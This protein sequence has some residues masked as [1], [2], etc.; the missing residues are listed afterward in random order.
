M[1]GFHDHFSGLNFVVLLKAEDTVNLVQAVRAFWAYCLSKGVTIKRIHTDNAKPHVSKEMVALM[2][3]EIKCRYTTI[4]PYNPRANG[5]MERQWRTMGSETVKLLE[6]SNLPRNF[7]W[8][9]LNQTVSVR[10]T[11][12]IRGDVT[13]CPLSLF[14]GVKPN[15]SQFRVFGCVV[16]AKIYNRTSKMSNQA[17]RCLHLGRAP[18]QSGYIC[19]EPTTQRMIT[20]AHCRFVEEAT[21]GLVIGR[22]G[23]QEIVPDF[24]DD[25]DLNAERVPDILDDDIS[26]EESLFRTDGEPSHDS[27]IGSQA[28]PVHA[29]PPIA[30]V[31]ADVPMSVA[32]SRRTGV[33]S[34]Y[35][36]TRAPGYVASMDW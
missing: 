6:K 5:V 26:T 14:T 28:I 33:N 18:N 15:A 29:S 23:Y 17:V 2:R 30:R 34:Q 19:L 31:P 1:M 22:E 24:A 35:N 32:R 7:A 12:P 3:D 11:L 21:P 8:Y 27:L 4:A 36:T 20:A 16:Y 13:N 10:N 9:A 25:F